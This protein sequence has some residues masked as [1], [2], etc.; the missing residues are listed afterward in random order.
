MMSSRDAPALPVAPTDAAAA[1]GMHDAAPV[2]TPALS[3]QHR[4]AFLRHLPRR[5][6]TLIRRVRR[7]QAAG[8]D[9]NGLSQLHD[10]LARLGSAGAPHGLDAITTQLHA[11]TANL[12]RHLTAQQLPD[13]VQ[14][15]Q[16]LQQLLTLADALP[17]T[18]AHPQPLPPQAIHAG[19]HVETP[20][21]QYWRRWVDDAPPPQAVDAS[22]VPADTG[23]SEYLAS[24]PVAAIA[25]ATTPAPPLH[26]RIYHLTDSG[27]LACALDQQMEI[28]GYE[29]ELLAD[30][31]E[32][33]ELLSALPP[34]LAIVDPAFLDA[35][36][37][38]GATVRQ[39][40]QSTGVRLPLLVI[41]SDD[42][43]SLRL[44]ARRAGV[45]ALL[46]A[47]ADANTVLERI[48]AL[49]TP[50]PE[51]PFRILIVEDDRVQALF[52]DSVL[53]N[54]GMDTR[55]VGDPV[56]VLPMMDEFNPDLV[57]MD[58][59][60]PL[61]DGSEL[62]A[63]IR[64]RDAFLHT[65]IVFLSGESDPDRQF[66]ALDAGGD[67]FIAKPVAPRHLIAAVQNRVRRARSIGRRPPAP[68]PQRDADT[69]LYDR[70]LLLERIHAALDAHH[71]GGVLFIDIDGSAQ[72]R[73]RLG[74]STLEQLFSDAGRVIATQL[75]G[76]AV[77]RFGDGSYLALL[78]NHDETA[79]ETHALRLRTALVQHDFNVAGK[80]LRV[81]ASIGVC[82]LRGCTDSAALLTAVERAA[83][84]A[85]ANE[86][87]VQHHEPPKRHEQR[88]DAD[89]LALL[90]TA[91]ARALVFQPIVAVAGGEQ[92]QFQCFLRLRDSA[93]ELHSA[94]TIIPLAERADLIVELD[95]WTLD[96]AL[97]LIAQRRAQHGP[98]RLF[99]PQSAQ[100]LADAEHVPW[101]RDR[102][103]ALDVAGDALVI[104]LR[105]DDAIVHTASVRTCCEALTAMGVQCCLSQFTRDADNDNLLDQFPLGFIKLAGR[106]TDAHLDSAVRDELRA[107]VDRAHRRGLQVI[108]QRIEDP[109]SAA[110]MWLSGIDYIQGNLVRQAGDGLDFDFGQ[111]VL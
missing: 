93:G 89:L 80:P 70:A 25:P 17:D 58:L 15:G 39:T 41:A 10:N 22:A 32:L 84:A 97:Q 92:A 24:D 83:R 30:A 90:H 99:V 27:P 110:T 33:I 21:A 42:D 111:T 74:L 53:R 47:P 23:E 9:I 29:I 82:A 13:S 72:L 37:A 16:L 3:D 63:L 7:A 59:H 40:R 11:L 106:Y 1:T 109:Q 44:S 56:A 14:T 45:D 52:A 34:D 94:A 98:M 55:V 50:V 69:G 6:A 71:G 91:D 26:R 100:T 108:G 46:L 28:E 12:V 104:D 43:L 73:D 35:I 95:R 31:D 54:V 96:H 48:Q 2:P 18:P 60:M 62:T 78:P 20:P 79:L 49:L 65:P 81:R 103:H 8:W 101:L 68:Q 75:D 4:L 5:V 51:A 67:D 107:L 88:R 105:M 102:L 76:F 36:E 64:E 61:I 19:V 87:G 57:L 66:G 85:R 77:A 86:R 38:I